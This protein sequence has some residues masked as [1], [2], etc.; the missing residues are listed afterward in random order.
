[1]QHQITITIDADT[2]SSYT[3][4]HLATLWHVAQANPAPIE[5]QNA[6][7]LAEKIGREI[8]ARFLRNAPVELYAHQGR[9]HYHAALTGHCKFTDGKWVK[10]EEAGVDSGANERLRQG[11]G[12][13]DVLLDQLDAVIGMAEFGR[14]YSGNPEWDAVNLVVKH[15]HEV[16][17]KK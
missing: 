7:D 2:L 6:G 10:R 1:M 12:L 16:L 13:A 17:R 5:D 8:I 15:A 4:S 11:A 14:I 9:H 3:N